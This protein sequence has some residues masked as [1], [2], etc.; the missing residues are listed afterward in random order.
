MQSRNKK[1][2]QHIISDTYRMNI[3]DIERLTYNR[4]S[5]VYQDGGV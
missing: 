5:M 4:K 1:V 2:W 3:K